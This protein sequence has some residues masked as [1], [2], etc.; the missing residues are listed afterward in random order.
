MASTVL[1]APKVA[2]ACLLLLSASLL[3]L[4]TAGPAQAC[5][6]VP[7]PSLAERVQMA[8][9]VVVGR[10]TSADPETFG[11][12]ERKL[13]LAVDAVYKGEAAAEEI[14]ATPASSASCGLAGVP[15]D[16]DYVW[17]L[18]GEGREAYRT[19]LCSGNEPLT[20]AVE[21]ALVEAS[22][23]PSSPAPG[24]SDRP[25]PPGAVE[26]QARDIF[27]L[28]SVRVLS[29]LATGLFVLVGLAGL[30]YLATRR[31]I[32]GGQKA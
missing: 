30:G 20:P 4:A 1:R 14:V 24:A 7:T 25:A 29:L 5:S 12:Q 6:C 18:Q 15:L 27:D 22:G 9:T 3:I 26:A 8:D 13:T 10:L 16:T 2:L 17:F 19:G 23:P 31:K 21:Q 32:R 11:P 28:A